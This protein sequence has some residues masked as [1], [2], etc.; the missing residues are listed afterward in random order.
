MRVFGKRRSLFNSFGY[1]LIVK[2]SLHWVVSNTDINMKNRNL[3][4]HEFLVEIKLLKSDMD[5][6]ETIVEFALSEQRSCV[7]CGNLAYQNH[8]I[9]ERY[10]WPWEDK[11]VL[12][13]ALCGITPRCEQ[14]VHLMQKDIVAEV[15]RHREMLC[16][17]FINITIKNSNSWISNC[18]I[19]CG[20]T[21]HK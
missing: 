8:I 17:N 15:K 12:V 11:H 1:I 7:E 9:N 21:I 2:A 18:S 4:L 13:N 16:A 6:I 19:W 3:G 10:V 14:C 20:N 5:V